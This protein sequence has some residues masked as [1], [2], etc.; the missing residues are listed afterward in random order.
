METSAIA[1]TKMSELH[2]VPVRDGN[3]EGKPLF[4]HVRYTEALIPVLQDFGELGPFAPLKSVPVSGDEDLFKSTDETWSAEEHDKLE[5]IILALLAS[6]HE[7]K[8]PRPFV[9]TCLRCGTRD[10]PNVSVPL[11][12]LC[13]GGDND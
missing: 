5:E 3:R 11:C 4:L 7:P 9:A 12:S 1:T 2:V 8:G 6:G 10:A 13:R